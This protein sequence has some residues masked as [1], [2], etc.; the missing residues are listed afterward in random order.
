MR[1]NPK[2][3]EAAAI[4]ELG[5]GEAL[6]SC[7]DEKGRPG[8]VERVF[9]VPPQG[10]IGPITEAQRRRLMQA[11]LVSGLYDETVDRES[12]YEVLK[13]RAR[14]GAPAAEPTRR[15]SQPQTSDGGVLGGLGDLLGARRGRRQSVAEVAMKSAA[16]AIGT[17]LG[18]QVMRGVLGSILGGTRR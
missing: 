15:R 6:V 5:V 10:Q 13:A 1:D 4:T 16:R 7:L 18:R 17:E 14:R 12:A 9:V 2:L 11:S 3:D 8:V